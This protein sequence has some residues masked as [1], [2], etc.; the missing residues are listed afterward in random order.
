MEENFKEKCK[1]VK[2]LMDDLQTRIKLLE[3]NQAS[4][5]PILALQITCMLEMI[6]Y[7]QCYYVV[8]YYSGDSGQGPESSAE[9]FE[10]CCGLVVG[11][12]KPKVCDFFF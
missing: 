12:Y 4:K 10:C 1:L 11:N 9:Q 7:H 5:F 6:V 3:K 8:I 2:D